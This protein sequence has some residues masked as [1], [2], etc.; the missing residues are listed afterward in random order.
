[1]KKRYQFTYKDIPVGTG[2]SAQ[3]QHVQ[4][5]ILVLDLDETLVHSCYDILPEESQLKGYEADLVFHISAKNRKVKTE[6]YKRPY[7][8]AFLDMVSKWYLLVI[9][10]AAMEEYADPI[11]NMLDGSRGILNIRLYRKHC[12]PLNVS[13]TKDL[14]II[15]DDLRRICIIDNSPTAYLCYPQNAVPIKEWTGNRSDTALLDLLP[16]L[17]CL[18]FC[19]D[20]RSIL[21]RG[22]DRRSIVPIEKLKRTTVVLRES[23]K[24]S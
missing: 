5:K 9:Y 6:V 4:T 13:L 12:L 15:C 14:R 22:S 11:I 1:M 17:D 21:Q 18:R 2:L 16:F 20:V 3:L 7:V 23:T 19:S 8:D 10:T 24:H